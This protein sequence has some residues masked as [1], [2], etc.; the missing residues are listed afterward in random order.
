MGAVEIA[1]VGYIQPAAEK[2]LF[3]N[4]F[5]EIPSGFIPPEC[6]HDMHT[7]MIIKFVFKHF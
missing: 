3:I 5:E 2:S 6:L 4:V 7:Y 1:I